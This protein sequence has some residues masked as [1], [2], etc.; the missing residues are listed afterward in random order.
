MKVYVNQTSPYARKVRVVV[1]EKNLNGQV[2]LIEVDPW[3]DPP[4]LLEVSPLSRVPVL[5][6][7]GKLVITESD[8]ICRYLDDQWPA[9]AMAAAGA[10]IAERSEVVSRIG[11]L[12]GMIDSAFDA[13]IERRRPAAQQWPDWIS[14][15]QRA[16]E[17]GLS[18]IANLH[19]PD[20]RFD[21]GDV[22]LACL[23]GYL[24]FRHPL[25]A[26]R[27]TWP[28]LSTWFEKVSRRPSMASTGPD[29][30]VC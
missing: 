7:G 22:S 1:R 21:L 27:T 25:I 23:L 30:P 5:V 16:V 13:V 24:D 3:S 26:W 29:E 9:P 8:A 11:L 15:Q 18:V 4:A 10:G 2:A 28:A 20:D 14:R 6:T 17:R 12:Q 19:R